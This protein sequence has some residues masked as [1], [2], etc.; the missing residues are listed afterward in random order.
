MF[1]TQCGSQMP[2]GAK[3]CGVCGAKM[4]VRE[5]AARKAP[6]SMREA[7]VP[8][9]V[10]HMRVMSAKKRGILALVVSMLF[11]AICGV[12]LDGLYT[13]ALAS[14]S[15][16]SSSY[17]SADN[18]DYSDSYFSSES[19]SDT[20][21][22]S[23]SDTESELSFFG[24]DEPFSIEGKWKN[25]GSTTWGQMQQGAIVIFNGTNCNVFSP[26]DVY[27]FYEDGGS[28]RLDVTGLLGGDISFNVSV[29]DSDH[30]ELTYSDTTIELMR[31]N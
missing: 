26:A 24:F 18:S 15:T 6:V 2:D 13:A 22:E 31:V 11:F 17:Q 19:S 16:G 21:Y 14:E 30:I 3:F 29:I 28:Y 23:S 9:A 7:A 8:K 4:R 20:E 27:A 25:T 10:H 1:C 5:E 12:L